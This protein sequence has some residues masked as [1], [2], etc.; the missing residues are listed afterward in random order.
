MKDWI[1]ELVIDLLLWIDDRLLATLAYV[2]RHRNC[3]PDCDRD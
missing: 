2:E 3:K 1:A